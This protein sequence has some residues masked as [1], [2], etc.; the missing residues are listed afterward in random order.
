MIEVCKLTK[1]HMDDASKNMAREL[2][3]V[4]IFSLSVGHGIGTVD[5]VESIGTID[6]EAYAQMLQACGAYA[7]FKLGNLNQYF[8]VEI[9]PE[10]AT[11]L[12]REMPECKLKE[13]FETL[14]E[15]YIVLRK[16]L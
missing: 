5:F 3:Q 14:H 1:R 13:Y 8:E 12:H 6:D 10:H 9:F 11:K 15:G 7:Q 2:E 4:K 16:S